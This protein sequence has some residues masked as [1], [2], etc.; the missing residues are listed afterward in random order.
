MD[1]MDEMRRVDKKQVI[2]PSFRAVFEREKD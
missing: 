2:R 1:S